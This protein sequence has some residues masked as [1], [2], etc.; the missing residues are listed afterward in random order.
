MKAV[1]L[2]VRKRPRAR[3]Y[4]FGVYAGNSCITAHV[5]EE[6]ANRKLEEGRSFYEYWAGSPSVMV[7]NSVK[8]YRTLK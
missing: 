8:E 1:E 3:K 5:S 6:E 7:S 2:S 4:K